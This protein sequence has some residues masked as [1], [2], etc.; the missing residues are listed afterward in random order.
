MLNSISFVAPMFKKG[1]YYIVRRKFI[2]VS[3]EVFG[4]E[5]I[6]NSYSITFKSS[7]QVDC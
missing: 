7:S 1:K 2:Y 3:E 5:V 6:L 4:G